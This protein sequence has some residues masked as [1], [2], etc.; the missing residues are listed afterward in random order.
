MENTGDTGGNHELAAETSTRGA[1][2]A[3]TLAARLLLARH[4]AGRLSQR[5]AAD[6]CGLSYASWS[7]WEEG[8]LPRDVLDVV[9]RVAD[10]LDINRDWLLF[11]GPL[12]PARGKST[13][14]PPGATRRYPPR[15]VRSTAAGLVGR[16][17]TGSPAL[18]V[19]RTRLIDRSQPVAA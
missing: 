6:K 19:R 2:P 15:T 17:V 11:G 14:R 13:K 10:A 12:L 18:S 16:P 9:Q 4:H 1:I 8:R 3:D 7:N 5:E